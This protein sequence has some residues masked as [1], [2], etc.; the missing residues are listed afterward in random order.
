M[1]TLSTDVRISCIPCYLL[2]STVF[3]ICLSLH[4][5][6][7]H[8]HQCSY[9]YVLVIYVHMY[10]PLIVTFLTAP[11]NTFIVVKCQYWIHFIFSVNN[12]NY[13]GLEALNLIRLGYKSMLTLSLNLT[14]YHYFYF[15]IVI[16][17]G[18]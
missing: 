14:D 17:L 11:K 6:A 10:M 7:F 8:V 1:H 12:S 3:T 2:P 18:L 13:S 16:I 15:Y 9:Q 4:A 5:P